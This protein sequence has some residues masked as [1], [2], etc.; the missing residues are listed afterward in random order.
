ML[1]VEKK[2]L[3]GQFAMLP[4]DDV[5]FGTGSVKKLEMALN[6]YGLNRPVVITGKSLVK[7]DS[8]MKKC[9]LTPRSARPGP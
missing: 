8:L 5:Y 2:D 9:F 3:N 4:M 6:Q 1:S 7:N